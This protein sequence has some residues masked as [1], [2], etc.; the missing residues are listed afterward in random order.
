MPELSGA[1]PIAGRRAVVKRANWAF[2]LGERIFSLLR[3]DF[4]ASLLDMPIREIEAVDPG[5]VLS[6]STSDM[7][8]VAEV[9][10]TGVPEIL[11]GTVSV[12]T[13]IGAAFVLNPLVALGCLVGLP[14]IVFSTRWYVRRATSVYAEQLATRATV[15][16]DIAETVR[17]H[18]VVG[19][20]GL[21]PARE[22]V[23]R[24]GIARALDKAAVPVW[25]EQ[26]WFP[27][28]QI[29]YHLPL[30]VVLAWG[31]DLSRSGQATVGTVAAIALYV[32]SIQQPLDDLIYWFG[33]SQSAIAAMGRILGVTT[34]P[35]TAAAVP[36]TTGADHAVEMSDVSFA[37]GNADE[38][39]TAVDL[40][41]RQGSGSASSVPLVP[42]RRRWRCCSPGC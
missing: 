26:R 15:A 37:Y 21:G 2:A 30:L 10:R 4:S 12:A 8:A 25:L 24:R 23:M 42:A 9:A 31:A 14:F 22:R 33:E 1:L 38:A 36:A 29:G 5:E 18:D 13:T 3:M 16:G 20:H 27:V 7:D 32:R 6:R 41:V 19:A 40:A 17:G 34:V 28:V 11:V 35:R 39:L